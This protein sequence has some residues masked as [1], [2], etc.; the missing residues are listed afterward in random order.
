ME[1]KLIQ[2]QIT[3]LPQDLRAAVEAVLWKS[4][5]NEIALL[6]KLNLEQAT[7]V[8]REVMFVLY[9]F[10][11]PRKLIKNLE[12]EVEIKEDVAIGLAEAIR[13]RIFKPIESRLNKK[14]EQPTDLPM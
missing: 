2:E 4:V 3:K 5:V 14:G 9:G 6:N 1:D 8:E 7:V 12:K 11:D 10:E 13:E